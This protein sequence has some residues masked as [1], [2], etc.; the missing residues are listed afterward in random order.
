MG[1]LISVPSTEAHSLVNARTRHYQ[2]EQGNN[3]Q[4]YIDERQRICHRYRSIKATCCQNE[5]QKRHKMIKRVF[6]IPE[7]FNIVPT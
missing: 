7:A 4:Y 2:E 3:H 5:Q 1:F 6:H